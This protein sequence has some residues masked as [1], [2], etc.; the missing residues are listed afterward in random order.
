[1]G[2]QRELPDRYVDDLSAAL[3]E[4]S[5]QLEPGDWLLLCSDGVWGQVDDGA[6]STILTE[7]L[8]C[9]SAVQALINRAL[10]SGAPDNASA[11]V[12]RC[13]EMETW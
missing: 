2:S 13:V 3:G 10:Q 8:S 11:I 9:Q 7:A 1:L 4:P 12:A 5:L 6:I